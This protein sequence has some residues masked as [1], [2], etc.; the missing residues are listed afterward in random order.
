MIDT[1][2]S[3]Q[4]TLLRTVQD[5]SKQPDKTQ[6]LGQDDFFRL[7]TTQL[8]NQDP[9]K[10]MD[11]ENFLAQ[12]AQFSMVSGIGNLQKSFDTLSQSLVSNQALQA[13]NL[14]GRQVLA[15]SG[16]AT[17]DANG[18]LKG[19]VDLPSASSQ[20][21][22]SIQDA[23]GQTIRRLE[24]GSQTAGSVPFQWNGM[25]DDGTFAAPGRYL[26]TAEAVTSDG[27]TQAVDTL[28]ASTV[29]SVT[30]NKDGGLMLD[31]NGVGPVDF[32]QVR[33]IL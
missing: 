10:P 9:T 21:T 18:G 19:S 17:L 2:N 23:S 8:Q 13:T 7:M 5:L 15:P 33:E 20:V 25:K 1:T 26:V 30:L 27:Q 6:Q 28:A 3:T 22:V 24:L 12:I 32:S 16:V 29:N 11:S 14:V 31:L 4:N